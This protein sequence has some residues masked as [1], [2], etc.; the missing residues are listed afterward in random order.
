LGLDLF[1]VQVVL[2]LLCSRISVSGQWTLCDRT[3]R[4]RRP[5]CL[6]KLVMGMKKH[7]LLV[8]EQAN[9]LHTKVKE[10]MTSSKVAITRSLL[11]L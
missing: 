10:W 7:W 2:I 4:V 5:T 11:H 6:T 1:L 8:Q 3:R 9:V